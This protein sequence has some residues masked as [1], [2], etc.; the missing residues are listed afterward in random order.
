MFDFIYIF[1]ERKEKTNS[2]AISR[3]SI[4]LRVLLIYDLLQKE[5]IAPKIRSSNLWS[6]Q[7]CGVSFNW[8]HF[9]LNNKKFHIDKSRAPSIRNSF[10]VT[11]N[12]SFHSFGFS[13][14]YFLL[15]KYDIFQAIRTQEARSVLHSTYADNLATTTIS[16]NIQIIHHNIHHFHPHRRKKKYPRKLRRAKVCRSAYIYKHCV[17]YAYTIML[18]VPST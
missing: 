6:S 11:L 1:N 10:F 2:K 15:F 9:T 7:R 3:T 13:I 16:F 14:Y 4:T 5:Q 12:F 17:V 8:N 18:C